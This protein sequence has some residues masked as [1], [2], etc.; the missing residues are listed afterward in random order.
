MKSYAKPE[1]PWGVIQ[2]FGLLPFVT[3]S[4]NQTRRKMVTQI[5]AE[6]LR[7]AGFAEVTEIPP[8]SPLAGHVRPEEIARAHQVDAVFSGS[9]DETLG[10]VVHVQ[11]NDGATGDIL[12]SGTY[13]LGMG[14]E[15]FNIRSQQQQFQRAFEKL[16]TDLNEQR[17][18]LYYEEYGYE[19]GEGLVE[20]TIY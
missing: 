19:T 3:P 17:G 4:E 11:L 15:F 10:T 2:R 5:F 16:V 9:V 8:P 7:R 20:E 18:L 14:T 13:F 6:E 1:A 12:W